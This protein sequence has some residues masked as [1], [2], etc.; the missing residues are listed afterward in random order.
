M[1]RLALYLLAFFFATIAVFGA[2][3]AGYVGSKTCYGCHTEIYR[4]FIK[5]DM[6]RSLHLASDLDQSALPAEASVSL[7][8]SG[9][10]LRVFHD[11]DGWHQSESEPNV[12]V[13]E[14]KLSY[15]VGAGSNGFTFLI[16]R[17]NRLFQ[18]PLSFYSKTA[19]WELSPGYEFADYAFTRPIPDGCVFCHSGRA[20]PVANRPAEYLNPPF[21]EL[22]IGCENCH[23]PGEAHVHDPKREGTIVNPAK[24]SSRLAE[25][26]CMGCHQEGDDRVLLPGK[27][28]ADIRPGHWLLETL[29][30]FKIPAQTEQQREQDLLEHNEAMQASRCFRESG[31]KLSCLTC[32]DPH[33][34]RRGEVSAYFRPKCLTCHNEQS[35]KVPLA[36]RQQHAPPDDCIGCHMPK[37]AIATISHSA[38]TNHR[39]PARPDEPLPASLPAWGLSGDTGLRVV[40][41]KGNG[42]AVVPDVTLLAAYNALAAKSPEYRQR[43][44]DL[45]DKLDHAHDKSPYVQAALAHKALAEGKN[46]QALDYLEIGIQ[47]S[48]ATVYL[49]KAKALVNVGRVDDAATT[50]AAGVELFPYQQELRKTL[51][52]EYINLK[53]YTDAQKAMEEYVGLF[54]EDSFMRKL[55]ERVTH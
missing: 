6:G 10:T 52:L 44:L 3:A 5:T 55:L 30:I 35:C 49:D 18:A 7:P 12:F 19:A 11:A 25:N 4:S 14:H 31:G 20:Q 39:I 22:S 24:L 50:L 26:I 40:D 2:D 43:F 54:P 16:N 32:H 36:A 17:G 48:D 27:S 41:R 13:D 8:S 37:R 53:R 23:G 51:I 21:E 15:A 46:E 29:A 28:Y 42:T 45:L 33:V 1:A 9:R 38:L 47:F 34:Q